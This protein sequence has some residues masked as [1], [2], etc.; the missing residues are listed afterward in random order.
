MVAPVRRRVRTWG[1]GWGVS[2]EVDRSAIGRTSRRRGA[3]AERQVV[4]FLRAQGWPDARRYLAGDGRQPGDLD[5]H[6]LVTL[7]V[8]DAASSRWPTWCRQVAAAAPAGTVPVVVRRTRTGD[9]VGAWEIRADYDAWSY[10]FGP[11]MGPM[12]WV[13]DQLWLMASMADLVA[14]VRSA[15]R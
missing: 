14:A 15:D 12:R 10:T 11:V 7:E 1:W 8:K 9:D 4:R 2:A 5:W 3:D 6:P 13:D